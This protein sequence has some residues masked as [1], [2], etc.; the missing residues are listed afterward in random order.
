MLVTGLVV[1]DS[2]F[3]IYLLWGV[4]IM[5]S[6]SGSQ[7]PHQQAG[8]VD[9]NRELVVAGGGAIRGVTCRG[10][11][12]LGDL[13]DVGCPVVDS[14]FVDG[15]RGFVLGLVRFLSD[16]GPVGVCGDGCV[17]EQVSGGW[18]VGVSHP[19]VCE[20]SVRGGGGGLVRVWVGCRGV[21]VRSG[22]IGG[23]TGGRSGRREFSFCDPGFSV[24]GVGEVILGFLR[25]EL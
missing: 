12:D 21:I 9:F 6:V 19:V 4:I 25:G 23:V 24:V 22:V 13:G 18:V 10:W 15:V 17:V 20:L 3:Y 2:Y 16:F 11:L 7:A 1:F 14:D 8:F 5:G